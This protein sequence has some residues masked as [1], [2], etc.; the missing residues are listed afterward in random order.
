MH[1][2]ASHP[3]MRVLE[4]MLL[5]GLACI[6]ACMSYLLSGTAPRSSAAKPQTTHRTAGFWFVVDHLCRPR[7]VN[8]PLI[9]GPAERPTTLPVVRHRGFPAPFTHPPSS[10][11]GAR[12]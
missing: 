4:C 3:R 7:F 11:N 12:P 9:D 1:A 5:W 8:Q 2:K 6:D 10:E